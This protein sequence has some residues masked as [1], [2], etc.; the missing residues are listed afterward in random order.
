MSKVYLI[1][2]TE[3]TFLSHK[4][5]E[6][7]LM[8]FDKL[9]LLENK[10]ES[11][12]SNSTSYTTVK[13]ERQENEILYNII[14]GHVYFTF[15]ITDLNNKCIN[16]FRKYVSEIT[17]NESNNKGVIT[18]SSDSLLN[19]F[20]NECCKKSGED[21]N[22]IANQMLNICLDCAP[23]IFKNAGAPCTFEECDKKESC[24]E[25]R[26]AKIKQIIKTQ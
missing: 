25:K 9:N 23:N 19:F 10:V 8:L 4:D 1:A 13:Y 26:Q 18:L 17:F 16:K 12:S 24:G 11:I 2:K 6:K 3:P 14:L 21:I 7:L 20:Q 15:Y 5:P 22:T